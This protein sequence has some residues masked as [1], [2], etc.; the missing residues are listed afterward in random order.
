MGLRVFKRYT[1]VPGLTLNVA[2]GGIS[3]TFGI[4]HLP[5][6]TISR[7][8][9][10]YTIPLPLL[11]GAY[12]SN[13]VSL[14][15][16]KKPGKRQAGETEETTNTTRQKVETVKKWFHFIDTL[17]RAEVITSDTQGEKC[18]AK[19]HNGNNGNTS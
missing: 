9:I 16:S 2:K 8:K 4:R 18:H 6:V 11:R 14:L 5:Q 3:A 19:T 1:I 12:I 17:T 13:S 15:P 10:Q 7:K